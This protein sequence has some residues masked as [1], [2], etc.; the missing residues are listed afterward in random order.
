MMKEKLHNKFLVNFLASDK[1]NAADIMEAGSGYV[2]PGIVSSNFETIEAAAAKVSELKTVSEV[3]SIG[4]GEGGNTANWKQV[5]EIA[6][7]SEA[8]HVNQPFEKAAYAKGFLDG[9]R[10]ENQ[11][12]NGLVQPT[13]ERGKVRLALTGITLCVEEFLDIASIFGLGSIKMMPM[14]GTEHL[15]ELV[16]ITKAAEERGIRGVEPAGGIHADNISEII[17]AVKDINIEF[18]M[19]HIFGSTIDKETGKTIP[20]KVREIFSAIEEGLR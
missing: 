18:F 16:Y 4:L 2:V 8:G 20:H 7:A 12:V 10:P 3:V 13:G 1:K 11:L 17:S 5:L 15:Q 14:N 9:S 19:P 6:A